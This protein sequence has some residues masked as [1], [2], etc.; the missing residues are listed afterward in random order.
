MHIEG[1][2]LELNLDELPTFSYTDLSYSIE[3]DLPKTDTVQKKK[4]AQS[5]AEIDGSSDEMIEKAYKAFL[6]FNGN[7][8][9]VCQ[10]CLFVK[11]CCCCELEHTVKNTSCMVT[12]CVDCDK[13]YL[14]QRP[15]CHRSIQYIHFS[16][17]A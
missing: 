14:F 1:L 12:V 5:I 13:E 6:E 8:I 15:F 7:C 2:E 17:W 11:L 16:K 9:F 10:A 3:Q 4:S